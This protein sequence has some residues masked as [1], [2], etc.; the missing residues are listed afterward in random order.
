MVYKHGKVFKKISLNESKLDIIDYTPSSDE[1]YS[2]VRKQK[3]AGFK[4]IIITSEMMI[5]VLNEYFLKRNFRISSIDF[6]IEDL[7]LEA[8]VARILEMI[9]DDRGYY[10]VLMD[11][12][13]FL[14]EETSIDIKKI[15]LKWREK[16][17]AMTLY[18]QVNGI[19]GI[20]EGDFEKESKNL[21]KVIEGCI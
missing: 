11:K 19:F 7:S 1:Y 12:L 15:E 4:Q 6:M 13:T 5:E 16:N 3:D 9:R 20:S 8:E 18:I 17:H 14:L 2:F 10:N 21:I